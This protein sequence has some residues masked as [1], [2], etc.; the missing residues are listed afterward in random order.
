MQKRADIGLFR[1]NREFVFLDHKLAE[2]GAEQRDRHLLA[3]AVFVAAGFEELLDKADGNGKLPDNIE[4]QGGHGPLN[5]GNAR[6]ANIIGRIGNLKNLVG[7]RIILEN[8]LG[9]TVYRSAFIE[10]YLQNL[11]DVPGDGWEFAQIHL[12]EDLGEFLIFCNRTGVLLH[13]LPFI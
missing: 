7:E 2:I 13:A 6:S 12:G 4:A 11:I 10:G 9:N 3:Q 1:R 8:N 5:G